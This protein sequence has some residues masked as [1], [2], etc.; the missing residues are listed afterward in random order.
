MTKIIYVAKTACNGLVHDSL[1]IEIQK[2]RS[3]GFSIYGIN[4]GPSYNY[5]YEGVMETRLVEIFYE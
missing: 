4:E 1:A 5:K 3:E 2:L